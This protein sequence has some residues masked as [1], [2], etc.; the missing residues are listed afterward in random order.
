MQYSPS[1][2]SER[3]ASAQIIDKR[4]ENVL[5]VVNPELAAQ[6]HPTKNGGLTP[7]MV[8]KASNKKV[9]W[10]GECGHEWSA[11]VSHRNQGRRCPICANDKRGR[12]KTESRYIEELKIK[13]PAVKLIG[14]YQGGHKKT[15]FECNIC[16][17]KW[18]AAPYSI[19]AGHGCPKCYH[20]STSFAEQFISESLKYVLGEDKVVNRNRN[21]IGKELDIYIPSLKYAIEFNGWFWHKDRLDN[22]RKK[23]S[24]C[25]ENGITV[26]FIY[27]AC[28][29]KEIQIDAEYLLYS[30]DLSNEPGY[31][32]LKRIVYKIIDDLKKSDSNIK[33]SDDIDW[34]LI[35]RNAFFCS[36]R[37]TTEDFKKELSAINNNI[38]VLSEYT[39][40][41]IPV[42]CRCRK[43][44]NEWSN[45]PN[46]LL[47]HA[48]FCPICNSRSKYGRE[49]R[50]RT[51]NELSKSIIE[52]N[53]S[54]AE[55]KCEII[56]E[57][58][59]DSKIQV[60]CNECGRIWMARYS[61][62]LRGHACGCTKALNRLVQ[63][64]NDLLTVAPELE[65]EWD[66][67]RNEGLNPDQVTAH[68]N[69]RVHWKCR[70]CGH[71]WEARISYRTN[72]H[73]CPECAK[74]KNVGVS[75]LKSGSK[76]LAED[77]P[78]LAKE[79]SAKKDTNI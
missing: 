77:N 19:I 1:S 16:G 20:V 47:S 50:K 9:W 38:V 43:C 56:G 48:G 37:K 65:I 27:D 40:S 62:L 14:K 30:F 36:R 60:R 21:A 29:E 4:K 66:Y 57:T 39:K 76:S 44:G 5:S 41:D 8:T 54:F 68:S 23:A 72:G 73:G 75:V 6:W 52:N 69:K 11:S 67:G 64:I 55:K 17:N 2:F 70:K 61:D 3:T 26:L 74:K 15:A 46:Q 71:R 13:N 53:P 63:G 59:K 24:L 33:I 49:N 58:I 22:D 7:D 34:D 45:T 12:R 51:I 18:E 78:L 25:N 79:W 32:T 10:L 35:V 28:Q 31:E 42:L